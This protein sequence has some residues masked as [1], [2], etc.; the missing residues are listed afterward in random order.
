MPETDLV[1][2][3]PDRTVE[4]LWRRLPPDFH[5]AVEMPDGRVLLMPCWYKRAIVID[6]SRAESFDDR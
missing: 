2:I 4:A 6:D 1:L 5:C 3:A